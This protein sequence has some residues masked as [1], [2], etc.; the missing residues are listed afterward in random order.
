MPTERIESGIPGL[1]K[2]IEGGFVNNSVNLVAGQTGTGKTLFCMQ[3]LLHGLKKG[4]NGVYI[5][6]EQKEDEI[7]QDVGKFGWDAE[8]QKY[9]K[10]GKFLVVPLEPTGIKEL[11][12]ATVNYIKKMNAKRFV[13]D[14]LSIATM[15]WKTGEMDL[16]KIRA[17]VFAYMKS[18][19]NLG[20]TSLLITEIPETDVKALSRFGFEEFLADSVLV[21]HYLEYAAGGTP[22]SLLIRK[23]RRTK[24][25]ADIYPFGI[26]QN[27]ILL[28][29]SY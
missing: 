1:D 22:R 27:G 14:S 2:L 24:H 10:S 9:I 18:L 20:V 11:T 15:G 6:L 21:L 4:E 12:I 13:L 26:E 5:T 3:Y 19:K 25:G 17:E 16:T 8:F 29:K 28:K 23:M 7:L